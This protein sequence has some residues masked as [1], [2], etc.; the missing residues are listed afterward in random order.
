MAE[1]VRAT[2]KADFGIATTGVA[3][4]GK[5]YGQRAGTVWIAIAGKGETTAFQLSLAGDRAAV[6]QAVIESAIAAF[7]RILS[8]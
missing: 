3:G 7:T 8:S 6:R 2:F 4:P 5:A 1:G